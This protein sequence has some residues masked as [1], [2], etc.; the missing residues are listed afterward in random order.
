M[1]RL[2]LAGEWALSRT[3]GT[4]WPV[5]GSPAPATLPGRLPGSTYLDLVANGAEDPFWGDRETVANEWAHHAYRYARTFDLDPDLLA[6]A[7][8]DLVVDGLDTLCTVT[9]NGHEVARTDNVNRTWRLD[10]TGLCC[11]TGNTLTLD[12]AD[13]YPYIEARQTAD[14]LPAPMTPIP[15]VGHLRKTVCHFGWDWGPKLPPAGV[16]RSIGLEAW[17]VRLEDLRIRQVHHDGAV[18]LSVSAVLTGGPDVG[19]GLGGP[20]AGPVPAG[21]PGAEAGSPTSI[22]DEGVH[23]VL[24]LTDPDGRT[25]DHVATPSDVD[26]APGALTWDLGIEDPQLWWCNGLGAQ[27][28]YDVDVVV[29]HAAAAPAAGAAELDHVHRRIGLRTIELDTASDQWGDQFRFVI[30]GVPIFAKGANWIPADS[31]PT[32]ADAETVDFYVRTAQRANMNMLRVWGGGMFE[33]EAF[34]DACDRHGLL[35]WQDFLFACNA[36]PFHDPGFVANVRAEVEDNVRRLRHRASL[37]LWCGNNENEVFVGLW[38]NGEREKATNPAFYHETLRA[39]VDELDGVTPYWPGSPSSGSRDKRLHSMAPGKTWGDTHLWNIWHGMR[40]IEAF[41]EYPTR[42][43]SEYGMESMPS[44][45]T[46]RSFTDEEQPGLFD[47][48]MTVHQKCDSGNAKVLY[49]LLAKY[50]NPAS[51]EDFV[52]LSQLVQADTVGFA[53]DCW[54]R[55]IGRQ[56]GALHWQMNDCWPV[57]SWAGVDYGRQLKA[58]TY[59]ARHFNRMLC[60]SNDYFE[61]RAELHVVNEYPTPFNGTLEWELQ[62]FDGSPISAGTAPVRVGP[63]ASERVVVLR[64]AD[65]LRGR[66]ADSAVLVARLVGPARDVIDEAAPLAVSRTSGGGDTSTEAGEVVRDTKDW[67]LVPDRDAALPRARVDASC[68]VESGVAT[69]TLTSAQYARDVFVQAQGVTAPW[70]DNF[71]DVLPGRPVTLTVDI[72]SGM[73]A[74]DLRDRLRVKTLADVRPRNGRLTDRW[75]RVRMMM[76]SKNWVSYLIYKY[77]LKS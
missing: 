22:L 61:D 44:M 51:F 69:V 65:I 18:R 42:F 24:T 73:G 50:R 76:G 17:D 64:H 34:Y 54:R 48:V 25:S 52:Y 56:N 2:D 40:P 39:W 23:A 13:P 16:T 30:N 6:A 75:T 41:R 3:D 1:R 20:H 55:N 71:M 28:L 36:Y 29:T 21:D 37:A 5:G 67:L 32:R 19:P 31:F 14:P 74:D 27:P 70:S 26:G 66:A 62:A 68:A 10:V 63:V 46:I 57:A 11:A 12:F 7:H 43:C 45:A 53:T 33:S 35:V 8:L 49:Y 9:V 59:K 58:V 47:P 77:V 72:P 38:K 60:L 15:G 4:A